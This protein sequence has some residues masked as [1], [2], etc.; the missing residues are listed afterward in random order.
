LTSQA[1]K[2]V[3][4]SQVLL[5]DL[6]ERLESI[7]RRLEIYINVPLSQNSG[8]TYAVVK[9]MVEVLRVLAIATKEIK[10]NRASELIPGDRSIFSPYCFPETFMRKLVGKTDIEDALQRL[11]QAAQEEARM[12]AA[13]SLKTTHGVQV[14]IMGLEGRLQGDDDGRQVVDDRVKDI[15]HNALLEAARVII[16]QG[17]DVNARD[18]FGWTLL[19]QASRYGYLDI[20]LLLLDHGKNV[21]VDATNNDCNTPLHLAA[22]NGQFAA[23]RLLVERGANVNVQNK[24]SCTPLHEASWHNGHP[25]LVLLLLEHG[26]NLE[27]R[28][29]GLSTPL[30]LAVKKGHLAVARLLVKHDAKVNVQNT[31]SWT[32]LHEASWYNGYPD[33]VL[34]LLEHGANLETTNKGLNT[35]LQLAVKRGH[36]AVAQLLLVKG[37]AKVNVLNKE[38]WTPL[39]EASWYNG[40]P[41]LV[42]LLLEHGANP[43]AR[44]NGRNTPLQLAVKRGHIAVARLLE[45]RGPKVNVQIKDSWTPPHEAIWSIAA[46]LS[47][48]IEM[49][50]W[51]TFYLFLIYAFCQVL[52]SKVL[53]DGNPT[54]R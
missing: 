30:Q 36:L 41:D 13:E 40:D 17:A 25:D 50:V 29:K 14:I 26:A 46:G 45:K 21:N 42:L 6:F 4:A 54:P 52:S 53:D 43:E 32:P 48:R 11:D 5:L 39:H 8:M 37:G 31:E 34:L 44:N 28:N 24:D 27:T 1:A 23:A 3:G 12:A 35:P 47:R 51:W 20:I 7:F 33:L 16:E 15:V 19:T 49:P 9:V 10:R 22:Q 18:K 38:S 2:A